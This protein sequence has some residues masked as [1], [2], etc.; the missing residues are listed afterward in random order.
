[1]VKCVYTALKMKGFR[2][3]VYM[4]P[5]GYGQVT[6]WGGITTDHRT[7]LVRIPAALNGTNYIATTW[8]PHVAP[9]MQNHLGYILKQDNTPAHRARKTQTYL[10]GQQIGV[11]HAALV[12]PDMN[13]F[14]LVWDIL[15]RH[16]QET[17]PAPQN[18]TQSIQSLTNASNAIPQGQISQNSQLYEVQMPGRHCCRQRSHP[19]LTLSNFQALPEMLLI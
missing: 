16:I 7:A 14:E 12:S 9:F 13:P 17:N 5:Q 1:M 19:I 3:S 8:Q 10:A 11:I 15:G 18:N 6:V 4:K 2:T